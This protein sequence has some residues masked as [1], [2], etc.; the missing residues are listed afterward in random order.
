MWIITHKFSPLVSNQLEI[1]VEGRYR[2]KVNITVD[3]TGA[4][5][6]KHHLASTTSLWTGLSLLQGR[7]AMSECIYHI[8]SR[9]LELPIQWE[10]KKTVRSG[11]THAWA[12]F[13][14]S[15][16]LRRGWAEERN[17]KSSF[18]TGPS[19]GEERKLEVC[20]LKFLS[21]N[22]HQAFWTFLYFK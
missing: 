18:H 21:P 13:S 2:R 16:L 11:S 6:W 7:A 8:L 4:L 19:P 1:Y 22:T 5:S 17:P 10:K 20:G 9:Q 12:S 15:P 14:S 3:K